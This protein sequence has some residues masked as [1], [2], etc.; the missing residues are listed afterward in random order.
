VYISVNWI[1]IVN[2]P[3]LSVHW[4]FFKTY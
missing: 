3:E 4:I 2:I 1:F